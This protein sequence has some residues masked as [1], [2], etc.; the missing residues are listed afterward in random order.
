MVQGATA[1]PG[2]TNQTLIINNAYYTDAGSYSA[3]ISNSLGVTNSAAATLY[4]G[5]PPTFAYLPGDLVLHLKFE[6][7]TLDS[8][9]RNNHGSA[10]GTPGF[11]PGRLGKALHYR[12]VVG[13][14]YDYVN[15]GAPTDLLFSSNVNFSVSY[16]VR[17]TG[18][19]GDLPFLCSAN[20]SYGN[21]GVTFAPGYN[22]G[23]W[24]W[25]LVPSVGAG[26]TSSYDTQ[27]INDGQWHNLVHTFDR[28]GLAITYFDGVPVQARSIAT[29]G[30]LDIGNSFCIGQDPSGVYAE[31]G[32]ADIDDMG[33]WRRVL[34]PYEAQS[35]Y[36]AAQ[37]S[38]QS[39]DDQNAPVRLT[40][41]P[42]GAEVELIW[43]AGTLKQADE[44][45]GPYTTVPGAVAP[46]HKITP[47]AA[48]KFYRVF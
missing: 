35:I 27:N 32:E 9:G 30:D 34:T 12:T 38:G 14:I 31:N 36:Y 5:A 19:P 13:S 48:K 1:V 39:F 41:R 21:P 40:V 43:Q 33:I 28:S 25:S 24:S 7:D 10:I 20:V 3:V 29:V 37:N 45:A 23:T 22:T 46:Y 42:A 8:S 47:G 6:D 4:V 16:W 18:L 2:A 17:F 44:A 11:V 15:L 26:V